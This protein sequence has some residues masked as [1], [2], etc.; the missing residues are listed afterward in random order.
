[1][2]DVAVLTQRV[3]AAEALTRKTLKQ[4]EALS[5]QHDQACEVYNSRIQQLEACVERGKVQKEAAWRRSMSTRKMRRLG[6]TL[7]KA[8]AKRA[9]QV[10]RANMTAAHARAKEDEETERALQL[11]GLKKEL[12]KAQQNIAR[13][14][15]DLADALATKERE[16]V[17]RET[18][19]REIIARKE[20][21]AQRER[22]QTDAIV[23]RE[24][25]MREREKAKRQAD[26]AAHEEQ[27]H[28]KVLQTRSAH[29][30][31]RIFARRRYLQVQCAIQGWRQRQLAVALDQQKADAV[32]QVQEAAQEAEKELNDSEAR[33]GVL[34][35][36]SKQIAVSRM[37]LVVALWQQNQNRILI[38]RWR[39]T[40]SLWER[41]EDARKAT[42]YYHEQ[43]EESVGDQS[44]EDSARLIYWAIQRWSADE[45][46]LALLSWRTQAVENL[47]VTGVIKRKDEHFAQAMAV[48]KEELEKA[49]VTVSQK[50]DQMKGSSIRLMKDAI[51]RWELRDLQNTIYRW[52][53][54]SFTV[55]AAKAGDAILQALS[56]AIDDRRSSGPLSRSAAL[57][58]HGS[59]SPLR[60][61][62]ESRRQFAGLLDDYPRRP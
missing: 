23:Q 56:K 25:E 47:V 55:T 34:H 1:M 33:I 43:I 2:E 53:H 11:V 58:Q 10:W 30:I 20:V 46:R 26:K 6:G 57:P 12:N 28:T 8:T 22:E 13:F 60:L 19:A 35:G 37:R 52:M 44:K 15:V 31:K 50:S 45:V 42:A 49:A 40:F 29:A 36:R 27:E 61:L 54:N 38:A 41:N 14:A 21:I 62:R 24:Q 5:T 59:P 48:K 9:A 39:L 16:I 17:Q 7:S 4:T 3:R 32:V 18:L 51:R